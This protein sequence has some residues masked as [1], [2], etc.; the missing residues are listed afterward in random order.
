MKNFT[1]FHEHLNHRCYVR[2]K[3]VLFLM[4]LCIATLGFSQTFTSTDSYGNDLRYTVTSASTVSV[5]TGSIINNINVNIPA[6]VSNGGTTYSV[7]AI[8]IF[9]FSSTAISSVSIPSTVISIEQ[10]A[11]SGTNL[12]SVVLPSNLD[13]IG[14]YAFQNNQLS[15]LTIPNNV[16]SIGNG[17]FRGNP[18]VSITILA[19]TPPTIT[20]VN[21]PN[22][23]FTINGDR[24]GIDLV[25]PAGTTGAYVTDAGALW[26][27]FNT[28]TENLN[29]GNTY[30]YNYITYQV[31]SVAN[32]TVRAF[33]YNTAGGTV[34]NIPATIPNGLITYTVTEIGNNAFQSNNLTSVTLP[35]T[36]TYIGESAF[37]INNLTSL[38]IPDS[39]ISID[40]GAFAQNQNM[41][42]LVLGNNLNT[43][44]DFAF[45]FCALND[46]TIPTS[47][48]NI[49]VIAFGGMGGFNAIMDIYCLGSTPP[50]I[51]TDS[52][53]NAD[54][55]NQSRSTIHL[56]IPAGT[57][58]AYVTDPG[59]LWTGFNP[60]TEDALSIDEFELANSV[61]IITAN[62]A[63]NIVS[64]N[65]LQLQDYTM[66][67]I[68]GIE[69]VRGKESNLPTSSFASGVY[70]LK[71]NFDRGTI[72]K[73]VIIN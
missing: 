20:T 54:T 5:T 25:I 37:F 42:N 3:Q 48:T 30:V 43:I 22:D 31:I 14:D 2:K 56:H 29:V 34:V 11:F 60:V 15:G 28:V 61:K 10:Q 67:S 68:S 21:G 66:Y 7:T 40:D 23:T 41:T 62:D 16:T 72:T 4:T 26:T 39:V 18:L 53:L 33:D 70:I 51:A 59:A 36:L 49:G 38:T 69:I 50:T 73:K 64:D 47:V 71:L 32:S 45:R 55:F 65:S 12:T 24:S 17:A 19:V 13:T 1:S 27:G 9:S 58:G 8:G 35:N 46:I 6:S 57:M 44:G 63:I 52:N